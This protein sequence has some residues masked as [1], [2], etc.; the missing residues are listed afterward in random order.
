MKGNPSSI[1]G[2]TDLVEKSP[3]LKTLFCRHF[4]CPT[5]D[6]EKRAFKKCLYAHARFLAPFLRVVRPHFFDR[7]RTFIEY[8]GTT[9]NLLDVTDAA[10]HF[11]DKVGLEAGFCFN[12]LKIRVS[13]SKAIRLAGKLFGEQGARTRDPSIPPDA[14]VLQNP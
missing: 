10:S 5:A 4:G 14:T 7:D 13:G 6:F 9:T 1:D 11:H 8:L 3:Q 12:V 2:Q